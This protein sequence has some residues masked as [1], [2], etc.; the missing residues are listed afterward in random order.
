MSVAVPV[1]VA[2]LVVRALRG[3][4]AG[5]LEPVVAGVKVSTETG[6]GP[7]GGPPSLPWLLVAEDGHTWAW[8]AVQRAM[9]RLT[10]WHR[11]PHS[12][13]ALAGLALGVLCAP[14]SSRPWTAEPV[15]GPL[16]GIDP[17]TDAPLAPAAVALRVRTPA[18]AG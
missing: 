16:A 4:L 5:R 2:E 6:R 13:K 18:E 11:T 1:D 17:S 10:C 9:I 7:N 14:G 3:L 12:S 8:P 15:T